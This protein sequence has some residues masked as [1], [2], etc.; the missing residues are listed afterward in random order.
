M[1]NH[2]LKQDLASTDGTLT[3]F[4]GRVDRCGVGGEDPFPILQECQ[5]DRIGSVGLPPISTSRLPASETQRALLSVW[6]I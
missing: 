1:V 2:N 4:D 6:P 3:I 5:T